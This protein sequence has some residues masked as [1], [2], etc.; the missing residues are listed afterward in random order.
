MLFRSKKYLL[1]KAGQDATWKEKKKIDIRYHE[2]SPEGYHGLLVPG[3]LATVL[4]TNEE[5]ERAQRSAPANSPATTRGHYIREFADGD[6]PVRANWQHVVIGRGWGAK[7]VRLAKFGRPADAKRD[8]VR[9][10]SNVRT[11]GLHL[12]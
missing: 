7:V 10:Q 11:D 9:H 6:E 12:D 3:G 2:L 1:D 4:V 8:R 5:I